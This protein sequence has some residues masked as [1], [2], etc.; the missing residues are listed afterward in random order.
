MI[1][2]TKLVSK[3][4]KIW[5]K[6]LLIQRLIVFGFLGGILLLIGIYIKHNL[7]D[8]TQHKYKITKSEQAMVKMLTNHIKSIEGIDDAKVFIILESDFSDIGPTASVVITIK[9]DS[10]IYYNDYIIH[11]LEKFIYYA[12]EGIEEENIVISD[13]NGLWLNDFRKFNL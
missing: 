4:W 8:W 12:I 2:I 11:R 3:K 6:W 5:D 9:P 7:D 1:F 10:F 13:Q